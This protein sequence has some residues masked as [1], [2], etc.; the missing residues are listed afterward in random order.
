M[1]IWGEGDAVTHL[2][3]L[4]WLHENRMVYWGDIDVEGFE[5]LSSLRA[6]FP[7]VNIESVMM[8]RETLNRHASWIVPGNA[9]SGRAP[10]NLTDEESATYL[11]CAMHCQRLEQEKIPQPYVDERIA[12]LARD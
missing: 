7:D 11:E 9:P 2:R 1:A 3:Q 4:E 5:A 12:R 8:D 10:S 6:I